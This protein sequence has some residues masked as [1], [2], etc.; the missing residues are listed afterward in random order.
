MQVERA[1]KADFDT[2]VT[3]I[4]DFWG[5]DRTLH[6]HHPS[7][8]YEFGDTAFV[9]REEGRV[10]AYLFG[11]FSQT[12]PVAY[13]HLIAVRQGFQGHGLGS[14]LYAHFIALARARGCTV[15]KAITTPTNTASLAFHRRLG[16]IPEGDSTGGGIPVVADYA[17]PGKDRV[18]MRML[19]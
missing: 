4:V 9:I 7:L 18:V 16:M 1:T 2:I 10:V 8:I 17:G 14:R 3:E 5:S 15:M 12:E 6:L 13:V 19:I 11:Y